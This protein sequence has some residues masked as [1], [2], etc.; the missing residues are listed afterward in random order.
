MSW[1]IPREWRVQYQMGNTDR[2][3]WFSTRESAIEFAGRLIDDGR[4]VCSV[5]VKFPG[6]TISKDQIAPRLRSLD[7]NDA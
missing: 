4:I 7:E 6:D 5:G 1:T 2:V 3:D